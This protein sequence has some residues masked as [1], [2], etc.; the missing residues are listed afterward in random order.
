MNYG[1][2]QVKV[3]LNLC[4]VLD[5]MHTILDCTWMFL[6]DGNW[7][8]YNDWIGRDLEEMWWRY[9]ENSRGEIVYN[10]DDSTIHL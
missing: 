8:E 2:G 7:F 4:I 6:H 10:T 5:A 3:V 1:L 9:S